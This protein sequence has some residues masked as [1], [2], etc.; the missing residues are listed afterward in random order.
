[1]T[2]Q[3]AHRRLLIVITLLAML[4]AVLPAAAQDDALQ[5]ACEDIW[6][7]WNAETQRCESS[8]TYTIDIQY[9]IE[10]AA[11][12]FVLEP[13]KALI[14]QQRNDILGLRPFLD[15]PLDPSPG[16]SL[17]LTYERY[18]HSEAVVSLVYTVA[19]YSGGA[20]PNSN[21]ETFTFDLDAGQRL[22]FDDVF[23]AANHPLDVI[24]P[25]AIAQLTEQQGEYADAEW[26]AQGAGPDAANF[27]DF[28]L[29]E[30]SVIF[31]FEPYQVAAYAYGPS[32]VE[33]PLAELAGV[34]SPLG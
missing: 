32:Q 7:D 34:I 14:E 6:G 5:T 31:F 12:D 30:D 29:T 25:L 24:S 22:T 2:T 8:V 3:P 28:A 4:L 19:Y 11:Y 13:V 18:Q 16:Y 21:Y 10:Y 17:N 26:I 33:I 9:P 1:M 27:Q 23:P 15:T 20:H